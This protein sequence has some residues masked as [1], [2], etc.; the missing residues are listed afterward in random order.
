[1]IQELSQDG[2]YNGFHSVCDLLTPE[3]LMKYVEC[4]TKDKLWAFLELEH[5][6]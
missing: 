4:V 5:K 1:M 6:D 2:L 3:I